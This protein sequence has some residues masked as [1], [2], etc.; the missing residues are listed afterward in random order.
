MRRQIVS[1]VHIV[2]QANRLPGGLRK[3]TKISEIVGMEEEVVSMQDIFM[4]K[5]TGV[6]EN[7]VCQGYHMSTGIRPK[8]LDKLAISG[9]GLPIDMFQQR[10]LGPA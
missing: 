2:I 3:I 10:R 4:F 7:R 5:Q 9:V 1:A 8:C 6:D